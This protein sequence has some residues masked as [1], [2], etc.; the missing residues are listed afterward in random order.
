ML[1]PQTTNKMDR[2]IQAVR[3]GSGAVRLWAVAASG[4]VAAG[5]VGSL[6]SL[7]FHK[8]VWLPK[9]AQFLIGLAAI[10]ASITTALQRTEEVART[11]R[12]IEAAEKKVA[13]H[14]REPQAAWE[15]AQ[16]KLESYLNRNLSQVRSIYLLTVI[17][18]MIGFSLIISGAVEAFRDPKVFQASVLSA[19][20]GIVVSFIGG[21]FLVLHKS[22]MNQAKDYV[23]ILE[24]INAVGMSMQ[25]LESLGEGDQEL[26]QETTAAIAQ[27]LLLMYSLDTRNIRI[28][29]RKA[30]TKREE[31]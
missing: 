28:P 24:R 18:M 6:Y 10:A 9:V 17:V 11:K 14:P 7:T 29:K 1:L 13:A 12:K 16:V 22:T 26:K 2:L 3:Y 4:L 23:T 27:Q 8:P 20:S 5:L 25:I 21:T 31:E 15:L 19:L 30:R